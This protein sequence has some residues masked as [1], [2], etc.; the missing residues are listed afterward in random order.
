VAAGLGLLVHP[1]R[2]FRVINL[3]VT[4]VDLNMAAVAGLARYL[5]GSAGTTW[6]KSEVNANV[7]AK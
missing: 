1:L 7:V 2:R 3:A 4:F 5:C 6:T